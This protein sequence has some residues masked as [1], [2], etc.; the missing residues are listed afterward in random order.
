MNKKLKRRGGVAV[1]TPGRR[2]RPERDCA[3]EI[4]GSNPAPTAKECP[5]YI[6]LRS[7]KNGVEY[8]GVQPCQHGC[9]GPHEVEEPKCSKPARRTVSATKDG[10]KASTRSPWGI[11][12]REQPVGE[13]D[14][15]CA[16][17]YE[18]PHHPLATMITQD[19]GFHLERMSN[20]HVWLKIGDVA[21]NL[22]VEK[23]SLKMRAEIEPE[24]MLSMKQ[25]QARRMRWAKDRCVGLMVKFLSGRGD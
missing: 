24:E 10:T 15:V 14:E 1:N 22:W 25:I 8:G 7:T 2:A 5:G 21:V 16:F 3:P 4:A 23:R 9:M 11:E 13:L 20:S 12:I 6:P 19:H 18:K 17:D